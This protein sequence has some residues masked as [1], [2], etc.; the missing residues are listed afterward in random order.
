[1]KN[2]ST[3]ASTY[4][5]S[6]FNQDAQTIQAWFETVCSAYPYLHSFSLGFLRMAMGGLESAQDAGLNAEQ[7]AE[8]TAKINAHLLNEN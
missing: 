7:W 4:L 8:R 3:E 1:M 5:Q 6:C 2:L